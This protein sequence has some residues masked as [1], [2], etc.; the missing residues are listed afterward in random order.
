MIPRLGL[1][2]QSFWPSFQAF[3][4]QFL[5]LTHIFFGKK[6]LFSTLTKRKRTVFR[7]WPVSSKELA[8]TNAKE[9]FYRAGSCRLCIHHFVYFYQA[10]FPNF[11]LRMD[12]GIIANFSGTFIKFV[13]ICMV[14]VMKCLA[15]VPPERRRRIPKFPSEHRY[16]TQIPDTDT[17]QPGIAQAE[18]ERRLEAPLFSRD[19]FFGK[20][21]EA[22]SPSPAG[23]VSRAMCSAR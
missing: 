13:M 3:G 11:R 15:W 12:K 22:V 20:Y 18:K 6:Q 2:C 21:Q 8:Q 9:A 5:H 7:T 16:Q 17:S 19:G 23:L 14:C 10:A 1:L 4:E